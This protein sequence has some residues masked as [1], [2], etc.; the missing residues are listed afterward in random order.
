MSRHS[1][2]DD[3]NVVKGE[4]RARSRGSVTSRASIASIAP[5]GGRQAE[6]DRGL[7]EAHAAVSQMS[8][9]QLAE[10]VVALT[11]D[12]GALDPISLAKVRLAA[13]KLAAE[14]AQVAA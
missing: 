11:V 1:V 5:G 3:M 14:I 4:T 6:Y 7:A 9:T 10:L 8:V 2:S 12:T 13:I